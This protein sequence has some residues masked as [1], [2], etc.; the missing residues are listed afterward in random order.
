MIVQQFEILNPSATPPFMLEDWIDVGENVRL[1]YRYLDLRRSEMAANLKLRHRASVAA[2][3]VIDSMSSSTELMKQAEHC[4]WGS[5]PM[6]NHTGLLNA[7]FC[8]SR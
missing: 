2:R 8:C 5:I 7:V 1:R 6:L 3:E 4:G